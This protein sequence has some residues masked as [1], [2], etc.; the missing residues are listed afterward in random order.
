[1]SGDAGLPAALDR[2]AQRS[3]VLVA[4]DF[5][6]TLAPIVDEPDAAAPLP[7]AAE[8]V[9]RLAD[10][11]GTAVAVVSGRALDGLRAVLGS[12]GPVALVGSHGAE[13][14]VP[15]GFAD[16][17]PEAE[18]GLGEE[19]TELLARLHDDVT[20][21]AR[22]HAGTTLEEKPTAVVLHTRGADRL[23]AL[24]A[25]AE[26]L[27]GPAR[28]PGVHV[29]PGKEVVELAVTQASKGAALRRLRSRLGLS[30]GG[31]LYAGDDRTDELA[32]GVLDD[33]SG[34]LTLKVGPGPTAA[35]HRVADPDE[36]ADV[37]T[38]L[39]QRRQ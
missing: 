14:E 23:V 8:A 13:L 38:E 25:T 16:G 4:L 28:R 11:P 33:G 36:L 12:V 31:V 17:D 15:D 29:L 37:L 2:F 9:R 21:I 26:V 1:V 35:R 5:D 30:E 6:G 34:D 24:A 32:F 7:R 20:E 18:S 22:R 39:A 3:T 27:L 10:S 19:A